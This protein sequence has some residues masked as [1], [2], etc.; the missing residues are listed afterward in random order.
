MNKLFFSK[1]GKSFNAEW[2]L[3]FDDWYKMLFFE[4]MQVYYYSV[5]RENTIIASGITEATR[6]MICAYYQRE[7]I[8]I[9]NVEISTTKRLDEVPVLKFDDTLH[10]IAFDGGM[11]G[12]AK[13]LKMIA[14]GI[15]PKNILCIYIAGMERGFKSP[16][17][18]AESLKVNFKTVR[19]KHSLRCDD[20]RDLKQELL[21]ILA[22]PY[23]LEF[24]VNEIS[25]GKE[26][27]I[28]MFPQ[29]QTRLSMSGITCK[30]FHT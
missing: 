7:S 28:D 20:G 12:V 2:D 9:E 24:G 6:D 11:S 13:L 17:P 21:T 15:P 29:L 19:V 18:I 27:E 30:K 22:L 16:A 4:M 10:A 1:R 8:Q 14:D 5:E 26:P 23:M 3:E 25:F